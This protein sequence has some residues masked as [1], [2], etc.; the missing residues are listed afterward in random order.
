MTIINHAVTGALIGA[1]VQDPIIALPAALLSHFIVDSLPH[2]GKIS[3]KT[4]AFSFMLRADMFLSAIFLLSIVIFKPEHW[5]LLLG[6]AVLAT[7]PDLMWLPGFIREVK[8]HPPKPNN[9]IMKFH[10]IIQFEL[11][12]GYWIEL[13]WLIT[14]LAVFITVI[15]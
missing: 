5:P 8:D 11:T 15:R 1:V 3:H 10:G 13:V 9:L 6:C 12:W 4:K 2:F 14:C 7:C